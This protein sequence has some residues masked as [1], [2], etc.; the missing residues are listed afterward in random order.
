MNNM[1][2]RLRVPWSP[3]DAAVEWAVDVVERSGVVELLSPWVDEGAGRN[4]T[5]TLSSFLD[6]CI[7]N[8]TRDYHVSHVKQFAQ[9]AVGLSESQRRMLGIG[10]LTSTSAYDRIWR[11]WCR[12][13]AA[14]ARE[15]V[16]GLDFEQFGNL[17]TLSSCA[18]RLR[19]HSAALDGTSK[20]TWAILHNG[21]VLA[22][23]DLDADEAQMRALA[24]NDEGLPRASR[25]PTV[26]AIDANGRRQLTLDEDA[27]GGRISA[28][29]AEPSR[30]RTGFEFHY[31][32]AIKDVVWSGDVSRIAFRNITQPYVIGFTVTPMGTH[33]ADAVRDRLLWVAGEAGI[34]DLTTD[35]GYFQ[36]SPETFYYPLVNANF[37]IESKLH[38]YQQ[39]IRPFS[40]SAI[41]FN[42]SLYHED[43][44]IAEGFNLPFAP[45]GADKATMLRFEAPFNALARWRYVLVSRDSN[46]TTWWKCPFCAGLL[47]S[48][49]FPRSMRNGASAELVDVAST[50]TTC[51]DG[52]LRASAQD[53]RFHMNPPPGT[54]A[55]RMSIGRQNQAENAN[56]MMKSNFIRMDKKHMRVLGTPKSI[57]LGAFDLCGYNFDRQ[58]CEDHQQSR[59][60]A[61][62]QEG[63]FAALLSPEQLAVGA[64][65]APVTAVARA[66]ARR[67]RPNSR[68]VRSNGAEEPGA[69]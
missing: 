60:A 56:S 40:G 15:V 14:L 64:A 23:E 25:Q 24:E 20:E 34:C 47:K 13:Y 10:N 31:I 68:P 19:S 67:G 8:S 41:I 43:A 17:L 37:S 58:Q 65:V 42:N 35:R 55:W 16:P 54:T 39:G 30:L 3:P 49:Q 33:R 27:R 66:E 48:R 28:T 46:G 32:T 45:R 62:P 4:S 2:K 36:L 26:Y 57:L 7:I 53:L 22:I 6:I 61:T 1:G 44:P 12:L 38:P 50:R 5:V 69:A 63:T 9:T 51:C 59:S 11:R 21:P 29:N 52:L 18:G